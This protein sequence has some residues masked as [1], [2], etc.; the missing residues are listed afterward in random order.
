M[1]LKDLPIRPTLAGDDVREGY[2]AELKN[3]TSTSLLVE[4][5]RRWRPLY[6]L[7]RKHR[8][9]KQEKDAKRFRITQK[10][11]QSLILGTWDP[12]AVLA[13]VEANRT[14]GCVH[15]RQYSCV[16]S[17]ILVPEI[18]LQAEFVSQKFQVGTDLA[19]IQMHG[20]LEAL[21]T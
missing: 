10:H 18:L 3:V 20:G 21:E 7:T 2:V 4:F 11:M 1:S 15:L 14:T 8:I 13:C 9:D 16:G 6:L 17:H 12:S 19:L 5:V